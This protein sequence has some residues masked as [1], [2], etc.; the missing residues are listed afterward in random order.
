MTITIR[1][2]SSSSLTAQTSFVSPDATWLYGTWHVTHSTLPIWRT[3]RSVQITYTPLPSN[4]G[5]IDDV[6]TY[7]EQTGSD[8]VKRVR[9][10]DTP[11]A[12]VDGAWDWRGRGWLMIASSH[13]EVLGYGTESDEGGQWAVTYFAKTLFTPSGI[14]IYSRSS[15]GLRDTTIEGI[16]D[17][18]R[19]LGDSSIEKLVGEMFTIAH[20]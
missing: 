7:Q 20:R 10:V 12:G 3:K 5:K 6:V 19:N 9:G 15:S 11:S 1:P 8:T 14:D 13:W 2:P 17:A 18:L 16:K 4:D